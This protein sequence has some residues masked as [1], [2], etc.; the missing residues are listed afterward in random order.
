[1]RSKSE[2]TRLRKNVI[3]QSAA[4]R[5]LFHVYRVQSP[6]SEQIKCRKCN[7]SRFICSRIADRGKATRRRNTIY[8][9]P[10]RLLFETSP[11]HISC[12]GLLS[13]LCAQ[14]RSI[15]RKM[16]SLCLVSGRNRYFSLILLTWSSGASGKQSAKSEHHS[17]L[18]LRNDLRKISTAS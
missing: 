16:A 1:M 14:V 2:Q 4:V 17:S 11:Q 10:F 6:G 9:I 12:L 3:T 13:D 5:G 15:S 18:V 7:P 8:S